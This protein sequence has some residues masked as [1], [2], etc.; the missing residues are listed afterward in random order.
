MLQVEAGMTV[1]YLLPSGVQRIEERKVVVVERLHHITS[2]VYQAAQLQVS[3]SLH[4][5]NTRHKH[6]A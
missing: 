3:Q 6:E 1:L 4:N 5:K 2:R